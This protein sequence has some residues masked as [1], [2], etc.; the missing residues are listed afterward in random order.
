[1]R[2]FAQKHALSYAR[3]EGSQVELKTEFR[4]YQDVYLVIGRYF[5]D[6]SIAVDVQNDE[7]GPIA[8]LTVCLVDKTLGENEAYI[9]TNNCSW[10]VDFIEENCLGEKTGRSR[11]SGYCTYPVVKFDAGQLKKHERL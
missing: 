10:A 1:M 7:D 3:R 9:D 11:E 8:R 4:V 5:M 6:D 2:V